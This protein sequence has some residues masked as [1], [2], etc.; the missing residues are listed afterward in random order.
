MWPHDLDSTVSESSLGL[1]RDRYSV[2]A[3]F[4]LIAPEP[5]QR[6]YDPIPKGFALTVDALE[7][8]LRL[9]FHPVIT[10]CVAWWRISPS[11]MAPNSWRY[12]VAFLGECYYA[13]IAP[14]RSLFLSC[15][16]L[17][18]GSGGYYLS[19]RPGFRVSGAP[20]SNKGWKER[21][22]YVCHPRSWSFGLRWAARAVDN[23]APALDEGELRA[24]RRLKEILPSSRV[25]RKMT[26]AWLVEAGLSPV[27]RGM[28]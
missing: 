1:L 17:S 14:S 12:L 23:T 20:S 27:P 10:A 3:E 11:Q 5:G 24:L 22:F 15:F 7:A 25:I 8:G 2:P 16:R 26:E 21:F 18:R 9:P 28:P 19:A 4:T 13:Q 6:A